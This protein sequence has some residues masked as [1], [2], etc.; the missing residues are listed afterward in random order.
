V[1]A[2]MEIGVVAE[3]CAIT[4]SP[5]PIDIDTSNS[6]IRRYHLFAMIPPS[7]AA[8]APGQWMDQSQLPSAS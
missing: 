2:V 7:L 8:A 6:N 1:A 4:A 3:A 5:T